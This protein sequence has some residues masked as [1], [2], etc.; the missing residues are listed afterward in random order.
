MR[1]NAITSGC[2]VIRARSSKDSLLFGAGKGV[3]EL[4]IKS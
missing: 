2:A 3:V 4:R 1:Q